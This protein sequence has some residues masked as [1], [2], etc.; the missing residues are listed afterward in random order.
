MTGVK[1]KEAGDTVVM[2]DRCDMMDNVESWDLRT[3]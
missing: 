1:D 2:E 3:P